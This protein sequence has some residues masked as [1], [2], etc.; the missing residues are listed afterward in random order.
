MYQF[1]VTQHGGKIDF[2]VFN[3]LV[4]GTCKVQLDWYMI[5]WKTILHLIYSW[6]FRSKACFSCFLESKTSWHWFYNKICSSTYL[7]FFCCVECLCWSNWDWVI[8]M[9]FNFHC[10]IFNHQK[11]LGFFLLTIN[12]SQICRT[13][14]GQR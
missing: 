4:I 6:L 9:L 10:Y 5:I 11:M 1:P 13:F 7:G 8:F 12:K 3:V 14:L 2:H